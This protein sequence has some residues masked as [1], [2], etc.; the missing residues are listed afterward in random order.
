ML[1]SQHRGAE[2]TAAGERVASEIVRHHR[3]LGLYLVR[4]LGYE[5]DAVHA[6]ADRLEHEIPEESEERVSKAQGTPS[7]IRVEIQ[8]P[9][10]CCGLLMTSS[11]TWTC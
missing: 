5:W 4:V 6:E 11:S 8:S 10:G 7:V 3:L 9:L 1:Y 2:L